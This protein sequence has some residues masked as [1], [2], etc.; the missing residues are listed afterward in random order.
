MAEAS[1]D[2]PDVGAG[3]EEPGGHVVAQIVEPHPGQP[4]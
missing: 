2:G 4:G 3:G 1:G